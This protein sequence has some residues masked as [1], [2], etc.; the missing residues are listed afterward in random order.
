MAED[1]SHVRCPECLETFCPCCLQVLK[2]S[3]RV[4]PMAESSRAG[5]KIGWCCDGGRIFYIFALLCGP[6]AHPDDRMASLYQH[7]QVQGAHAKANNSSGEK[8]SGSAGT[9]YS[10]RPRLRD[11]MLTLT[12]LWWLGA[13][14]EDDSSKSSTSQWLN[15]QV[16]LK[17][18]LTE[19][20]ESLVLVLDALTRAWP[21]AS[22]DTSFDQT[23]PQ[24]LLTI[25]RRS[26]LMIKVAELLR[27][28]C[29]EDVIYRRILYTKVVNFLEVLS[30]HPFS[31]Q[32]VKGTRV[33]YPLDKTILRV[34]LGPKVEVPNVAAATA[35]LEALD[36]KGK[37]KATEPKPETEM[38]DGDVHQSL[39][40]LASNLG[41]QA[42]SVMQHY[43]R[44]QTQQPEDARDIIALCERICRIAKM[45]QARPAAAI[46]ASSSAAGPSRAA[47]GVVLDPV[48]PGEWLADN[49]VAMI[50]DADWKS[51]YA[52]TGELVNSASRI[53]APGRMRRL[54]C[55]LSELGTSLPEG[56]YVRHDGTRPDAMKFLIAGPE[57]TPY[58]NGLWEFDLYCPP[59]YPNVPPKV[60]CK[61][62]VPRG[63]N[64]NLYHNGK[65]RFILSCPPKILPKSLIRC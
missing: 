26:P 55:E 30:S 20:D 56:I 35:A 4:F 48:T 12:N 10:K 27:D 9:G 54:V 38:T 6:M 51:Q 58:E 24:L 60:T 1:A 2:R 17:E 36:I 13:S 31:E 41:K 61:T 18:K 63:F 19:S 50:E 28:D 3:R 57:D 29:I 40:S 14:D 16:P 43:K 47:M 53:G 62:V 11:V 59:E 46:V 42:Q 23:P 15:A 64:P 52:Y 25:V 34:A 37:G 45:D 33:S 44:Q 65:G 49:K 5:G 21:S 7:Q 8:G 32:L 22:N 39:T